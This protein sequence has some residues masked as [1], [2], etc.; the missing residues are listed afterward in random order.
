MYD[1]HRPSNPVFYIILLV[2]STLNVFVCDY[3]LFTAA[4]GSAG[5]DNGSDSVFS[6][7]S[8]SFSPRREYATSSN[9]GKV[10][11]RTKLRC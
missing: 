9:P 2:E 5:L 3:K 10:I 11:W 4:E 6:S 1:I 7:F 8:P